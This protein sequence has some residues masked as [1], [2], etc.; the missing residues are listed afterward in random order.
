MPGN[1]PPRT[2]EAIAEL[3]RL[4]DAERRILIAGEFS[5]LE[6][7][8]TKK[9]AAVDGLPG[10]TAAIGAIGRAGGRAALERIHHKATRNEA[11]LRAAM[12]GVRAVTSRMDAVR[13]V[14]TG[15]N[16][17]DD[18]GR[19]ANLLQRRTTVEKRA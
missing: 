9:Q 8:A 12:D 6:S 2:M 18:Q 14:R 17:Y 5:R 13:Q 3:E 19:R 16:T 15:L 10:K 4:L 1:D 11:L 7:L